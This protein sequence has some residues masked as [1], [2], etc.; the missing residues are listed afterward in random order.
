MAQTVR[1]LLYKSG[2]LSFIPRTQMETQVWSCMQG[3]GH[4]RILVPQAKTHTNS[5]LS[6]R[7]CHKE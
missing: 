6:E 2:G 5:G 7:P 4:K 3:K 1:R